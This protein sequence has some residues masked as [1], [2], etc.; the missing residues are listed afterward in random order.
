MKDE[1]FP[2]EIL[3]AIE[4]MMKELTKMLWLRGIL[5]ISLRV[6]VEFIKVE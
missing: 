2:T 3:K 4:Q 6:F 5:Q 1:K